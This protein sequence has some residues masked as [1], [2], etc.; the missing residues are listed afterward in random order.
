MNRYIS[1]VVL[2]KG[3]ICYS[4]PSMKTTTKKLS[5]TKVQLTIS[6]GEKELGDAQ[7]V[8]LTKLAKEVKVPG[9]RKGKVPPSIAMKHVDPNALANQALD[10]A[11]SKAVATAFTEGDVRALERPSVEVKKYVPGQELEFTA[12]AEVLPE[13]KLGNYKKLGI[14][15]E[16]GKV[17]EKDIADII[18][19]M[20]KGFAERKEVKR[21]AKNGDEVVIDF[22]GKKDGTPFDGGSA[23]DYTLELGSNQF[24]P[25]F[26]EGIIGHKAGEEFDL[27]L[28]FP[29]EYHAP[30]LAGAKV[31]FSVT[32]KTIKEV[33]LPKVD[34]EFA[35]KA[36]PFK[37][38]KELKDDVKRELKAS[39]EREAQEKFK[40]KLVETL[41]EKSV[42]PAPEVLVGDQMRSIEQDM[43]QNLAYRGMTLQNYLDS[44]K[45]AYEEWLENEV[46]P[47]A[48][49]RIKAGLV[50]AELSKVEKITATNEE[51]AAKINEYQE[52]FGNHSGQDFTTPEI[53]RDIANRL[54][55][56]KAIDRLAEL[57]S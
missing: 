16:V 45:M 33:V 40:E 28:Q 47:A 49:N 42:A 38:V 48:V 5:D 35:K 41:V 53:Q 12:E 55:T 44:Q 39:R 11:I 18:E 7:Q 54:L 3:L 50:L 10:D 52:R 27:D 21:A 8:A 15:K 51:L 1:V 56:D 37:S 36:G 26:E 23:K 34:D 31:V 32:L 2:K 13:V 4:G 43:T 14:K 29:K 30:A 25:G 9:F 17:T 24:I 19:R 57:N 22:V 46:R 6:L 20:R